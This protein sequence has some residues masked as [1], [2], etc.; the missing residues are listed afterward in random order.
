[1]ISIVIPVLNE[2]RGI[3]KLL[4][5]LKNASTGLVLEIIVV[6]GGSTDGSSEI[7]RSRDDIQYIPSEKGRARQMNVGAKVAKADILYFLH[8][9]SF[10]PEDFDEAI[11]EEV[12]KGNRAGCFIMKFD[13]EHWWLKLMA[14]L[15]KINHKACRGGDQSLFIERTLFEEIGGFDESFLVYEDNILIRKLY[16]RKEFTVIKK[17]LV[18]SGRLYESLGVWKTQLLFCQIYW[19][20][21]C[22]ASPDD[23]YSYY[24]RKVNRC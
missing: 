17:W 15:T 19:K 11:V 1:M 22:G 13:K 16:E 20:K 23:L 7:L 24:S 10:P 9:D 5:H 3:V 14:Q 8:A 2:E 21:W 6:D 4:E 18:T 12:K